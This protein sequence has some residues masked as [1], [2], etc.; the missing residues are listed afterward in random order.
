MGVWK[1][2]KYLLKLVSVKFVYIFCRKLEDVIFSRRNAAWISGPLAAG[3]HPADSELDHLAATV[4]EQHA[5]ISALVS[6]EG[7]FFLR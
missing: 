2:K 4:G 5:K 7:I 1:G 3:G 6:F